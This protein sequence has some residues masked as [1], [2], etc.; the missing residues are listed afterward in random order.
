MI[1]FNNTRIARGLI[2]Y[3]YDNLQKVFSSLEEQT[4][5][6]AQFLNEFMSISK[7]LVV[8]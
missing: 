5:E 1:N 3:D 4:E 6:K 7:H 8:R 2:E